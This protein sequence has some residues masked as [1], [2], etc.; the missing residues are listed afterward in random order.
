MLL[1]SSR[2]GETR[3]DAQ[4]GRSQVRASSDADSAV[5]F[6][7]LLGMHQTPRD[8]P[9]AAS[10]VI[11]AVN[12]K[13][14]AR[15]R[16]DLIEQLQRELEAHELTSEII[17]DSDQL[18]AVTS[19]PGFA[20]KLRAVVAAGGDGTVA[21]V[22][23]YTPPGTPLAVLPLGTENLLSK[24]LNTSSDP[25]ELASVIARGATIQ[26][27]A[28][29]AGEQLFLLM[30]G[31]G[32]DAEVVRRMHLQRRGN[33]SHLSYAKPILD[34]IRNY[35]YPELRVYC[36]DG[37]GKVTELTARWVFVVNIPRYA[38]GL[39]ISPDAVADDGLLNVCT[40]KEGSLWNGLIY[41][42]GILMGQH[43]SWRDVVT[44]KAA[45][46]RIESDKEVPYQL[47][48][49]P[50]GSLPVTITILPRRLTLLISPGWAEEHG[51]GTPALDTTHDE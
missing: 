49:D 12:P 19:Q 6:G 16:Q 24:Y 32:F 8:L 36:R 44:V 13:A 27:D 41:L 46:V 4:T 29:M 18:R 17:T 23:N 21:R 47:D 1:L 3:P 33:I 38:G 7:S 2:L 25:H 51:F 31:C 22:A 39:E 35:Q 11:L 5:T 30:L 40:F 26:F 45:E 14:G 43:R 28:G 34:A 9:N 10:H 48:G 15:A 50:G 42:S 37:E 20:A